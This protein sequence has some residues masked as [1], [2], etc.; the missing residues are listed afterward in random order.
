MSF[1]TL[2]PYIFAALMGISILL[3]VI[4]DGYDL[5]VGLLFHRA[6][7]EQKD[8]MIASIGPFWDGNETW[9]VLAV[10]LLL[11]AFPVAHGTILTS[12]YLPVFILLIGLIL[13]GI[14]F[15]FRHKV[16]ASRKG[17]WN[18]AFFVGS[19]MASLSQGFMLGLY[20]M[21]LDW[22]LT[23]VVFACLTAICLTMAY[24]LIGSCWLIYKTED[25]LQLASIRWAKTAVFGAIG[26]LVLVSLA[27]PLVSDRLFDKWFGF[28]QT[29][30]L[31]ALPLATAGLIGGLWL[32]LRQVEGMAERWSIMPLLLTAGIFTAGFGGMAYS[33][34]PYI[35]PGKLT[36][37]EAASATNSLF[38]MLI[39]ALA[40]LPV[41]LGYTALAYW[42]F[43]GKATALSYGEPK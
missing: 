31:A 6:T 9:L 2:L 13:R 37:A 10:G 35:V 3:Y 34:F 30:Y 36:I 1:E 41:I 24:A 21:G 11:V 42:I 20:I 40:V 5:G 8:R 43:R 33:F 7:A 17:S 28:P 15:E 38:I 29:L 23:A 25:A 27:T 22:T 4:L 16:P 19:L 12:L 18:A 39:G 14:A 26:G 32:I